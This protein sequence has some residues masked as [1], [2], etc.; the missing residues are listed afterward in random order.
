MNIVERFCVTDSNPDLFAKEWDLYKLYKI[1]VQFRLKCSILIAFPW[2][3]N[4][5]YYI[6]FTEVC[7]CNSTNVS[8]AFMF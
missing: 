6:V 1:A 5:E 7:I 4:I 3:I 2:I 8:R